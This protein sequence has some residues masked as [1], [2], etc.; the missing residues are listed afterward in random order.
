M[1][2][3]YLSVLAACTVLSPVLPARA[4]ELVLPTENDAIFTGAPE[5]FYMHVDRWTNGV[6]STPW[7][8]GQYG[9]VR[10]ARQVA[11]GLIY[12]RFH[13]GIDIRPLQRDAKGEPLDEIHAIADGR[14]AHVS[15][16]ARASNYGRYIVIEHQWDGCPYYSLYAHLSE[17]YVQ[18]EMHV[19][20]GGR[21]ARMGHTGR[22]IDL[23]RSHVHLEVNLL[24]N[25]AFDSFYDLH[26]KSGGANRHGNFNGL[27]LAALDVARLYKEARNN[28]ALTIP[29]FLAKEPAFFQVDVPGELPI[30]LLSRYPW[31]ETPPPAEPTA[32]QQP[33]M[34]RISFT[35][36]GLP[37]RV[38]RVAQPTLAGKVT[39]LQASDH[40]LPHLTARLLTGTKEKPKLSSSGEQMIQLITHVPPPATAPAIAPAA[41]ATKVPRSKPAAR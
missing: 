33:G 40:S 30:D 4:I 39:V 41:A 14:V 5:K 28:P 23:V 11:A 27:N 12:T 22:G 18:P 7:E 38:Q 13:A 25:G 24:M 15:T 9:F 35:Q 8:G 20:A 32:S 29:Q 10:D 37:L 31:L 19:K 21:I 26:W 17:T 34:W 16:E 36:A 3:L 2:A 6:Q 1:N